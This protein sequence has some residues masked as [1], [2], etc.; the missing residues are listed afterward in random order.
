[1]KAMFVAYR[2]QAMHNYFEIKASFNSL[3]QKF[4][5]I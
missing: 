2:L 5:L 3:E 4:K 1:M